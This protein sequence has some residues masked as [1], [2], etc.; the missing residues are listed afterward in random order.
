MAA[1][2]DDLIKK[3]YRKLNV[4][5]EGG[6]LNSNQLTDG[7]EDVNTILDSLNTERLIPYYI[8]QESFTLTAAKKKYSIGVSGDFNTTRPVRILHATITKQ[9]Q[10]YPIRLID[11]KQWMNIW[12]K[13]AESQIPRWLYYE[14]D[15]PLGNIY[16]NYTPSETNTLN[17][18]IEKQFG[19]YAAGDA[20]N[21]PPAYRLAITDFLA[22]EL[23]SR[24]PSESH[25]AKIQRDANVSMRRVRSMN[26]KNIMVETELDPVVYGKSNNRNLFWD[27]S[28]GS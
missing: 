5:G 3:A 12:N 10:D 21:L 9:S 15:F 2:I 28:L 18:A 23:W 8:K 11:Y 27:G 25:A 17:L 26:V 24:Y 4:I 13:D 6:F 16:L 7:I 1:I 20:L 19:E 14:S 22:L